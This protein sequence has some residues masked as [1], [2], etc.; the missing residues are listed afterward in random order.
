MSLLLA[1]QSLGLSSCC[2]FWC[3]E[4][5]VMRADTARA[6]FPAE[7]ILTL[8]IG[9]AADDTVVPLSAPADHDVI[10]KH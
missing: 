1:L 7:K 4:P 3:V 5:D 6:A 2:L 10:R 8:A 9:Y